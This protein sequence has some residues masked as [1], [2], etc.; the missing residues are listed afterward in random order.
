MSPD[1]PKTTDEA[2][3]QPNV[4]LK[5]QFDKLVKPRPGHADLEAMRK[6]GFADSRPALE[7]ASARETAAR[8]AS[9]CIA[10]AF[11]AQVAG[12]TITAQ[13]VQFGKLHLCPPDNSGNYPRCGFELCADNFEDFDKQAEALALQAK[14]DGDTIGGV[15]EVVVQNLPP[16]LGSYVT[17]NSRLDAAL[18]GALVSIPAVK[19]VEFGAGFNVAEIPGSRFHDPIARTVDG[20]I[21]RMSNNAGGIEGGISNGMPLIARIAVKPIPSIPGG[22]ATVNASSGEATNAHSQRSDI[23][24]V[25]PARIVAEA[26]VA[27]TL[28]DFVTR[29][30]GEDSVTE[31]K[32]NLQ[33]Y[34]AEIPA[35][36]Q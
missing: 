33:A 27:L 30:F 32:R 20:K 31:V 15:V 21:T 25:Y 10:K 1:V 17:A 11:L 14:A 19:G 2:Q 34:L 35:T 3:A 22:L 24:A 12:I 23:S 13:V 29:K 26:M 28:A 18:A 5:E 6:Y 8:V 36:I 7:R 4:P 9:G 16:G